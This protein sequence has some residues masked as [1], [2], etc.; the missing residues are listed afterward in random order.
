MSCGI[1][2]ITNLINGASYIGQSINIEKRWS[3]EKVKAFNQNDPSYK[4][5]LSKAFRKYGIENFQFEILELCQ[6]KEL[7]E[8]EKYYIKFHNTY[9]DG[10]NSTTGGDGSPNSCS[11]ISKEDLITIYDLLINSNIPQSEIAKKFNVGQDV[12]S[13]INHGKSRRQDGYEYPLREN[14]KKYFCCDCGIK[15]SYKATRCDKCEK[16]KQRKTIRPNRE[17]LKD[18]IRNTS[19]VEIGNQ[20]NVS[21]NTI[22]KWCK[23]EN[24]PFKKSEIKQFSDEDWKLI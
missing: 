10:Y 1:Y 19:F 23:N 17:Q 12:I 24:L 11:K 7:D 5:N 2:K 8:K 4:S 22:R 13:T 18:L 15:I 20:Y 14:Q 21:D 9:Y 16:I 6:V 3:D